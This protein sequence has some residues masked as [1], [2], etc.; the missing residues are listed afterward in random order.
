MGNKFTVDG[1]DYAAAIEMLF[2]RDLPLMNG[3]RISAD[4]ITAC[5]S[6]IF[7]YRVVS[8]ILIS[9]FNISSWQIFVLRSILQ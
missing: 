9:I 7:P 2:E 3:S 1:V 8:A 4:N 5:M 6:I